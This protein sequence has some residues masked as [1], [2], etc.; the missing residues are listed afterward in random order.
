MLL[1][2]AR[3]SICMQRRSPQVAHWVTGAG[4]GVLATESVVLTLCQG[5][6]T[7]RYV[8]TDALPSLAL[9]AGM[10]GE[11]L[12]ATI[13]DSLPYGGRCY[14]GGRLV[15]NR[16]GSGMMLITL[17]DGSS[18]AA[19]SVPFGELVAAQRASGAP[20]VLA[21]SSEIPTGRAVQA[22]FPVAIAL[23]HIT[24]LRTLAK[25]RLAR[26]ELPHARRSTPVLVGPCSC[27]MARWDRTT[28]LAARWRRP[29]VHHHGDGNGR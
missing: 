27:A 2:H 4:F 21:T 20:D 3:S 22:I 18:V 9:E 1:R 15:R 13:I 16:V 17:P 23:S 11:A 14:R 6:P 10:M 7:P 26:A 19:G 8:R 28:G 25:N 12:A 5:R 29:R 24:P